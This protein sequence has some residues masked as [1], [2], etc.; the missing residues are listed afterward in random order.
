MSPVQRVWRLL[1]SNLIKI[2]TLD[3]SPRKIACGVGV[4]MLVGM[5]PITGFQ[6]WTGVALSFL[7]R[8]NK[9]A[10]VLSSQFLCNP[11]TLPFLFFFNLKVG[12]RVLGY[13][14][15]SVSLSVFRMLIRQASFRNFFTVFANIAKPLYLGSIIVAPL[16]GGLGYWLALTAIKSH[17]RRRLKRH[18]LESR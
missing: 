16:V 4:G 18:A 1:R 11:L 9:V 6:M 3:S 5:L 14:Q 13:E 12:E 2:A 8:L 17:Q 10:V 7:L 15:S